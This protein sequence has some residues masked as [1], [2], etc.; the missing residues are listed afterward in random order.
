[1]H[2][3]PL[4]GFSALDPLR[5]WAGCAS[6]AWQQK[7]DFPS[8]EPLSLLRVTCHLFYLD[9]LAQNSPANLCPLLQRAACL[10]FYLDILAQN[11][12]A[13]LCP[14]LPPPLLPRHP[15]QN[16]RHVAGETR[17][18]AWAFYLRTIYCFQHK[19][20]QKQSH[21]LFKPQCCSL[22]AVASENEMA[23]HWA[24]VLERSMSSLGLTRR[25]PT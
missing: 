21:L 13:N 19:H 9:I 7:P 17:T 6:G 2:K 25:M 23:G 11:R 16:T 20:L 14:L 10:L 22:P 15:A 4:G 18:S 5:P 8:C 3:V 1:M 24:C 12:P